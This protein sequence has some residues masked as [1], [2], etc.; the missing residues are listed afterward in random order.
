MKKWPAKIVVLLIIGAV[1][2]VA[3]A[4]GIVLWTPQEPRGPG[5]AVLLNQIDWPRQA[6][7][8]WPAP[9]RQ[10]SGRTWG[11]SAIQTMAHVL[12]LDAPRSPGAVSGWGM[13]LFQAGW[14]SRC[15]E[16]RSD[17]V[18]Y[19]GVIPKANLRPAVKLPEALHFLRVREARYRV[20][21]LRPI[22][23]G[24]AI[25]TAF[26][27]AIL[28]LLTFGSFTAR[29]IIRRKQGRCI[30]CGYDLR[31]TAQMICSECGYEVRAEAGT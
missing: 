22:W 1:V 12:P 23:P 28:W 14:P 21:P 26:Y 2:N 9:Q 31:G 10:N 27:A 8:D 15:I 30:N 6:P 5:M 29:R 4:W 25:N 18:N 3:V 16:A 24:F 11:L 7:A 17:T 20:L 19:A 13:S